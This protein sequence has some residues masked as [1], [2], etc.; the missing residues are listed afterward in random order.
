MGDFILLGGNIA[1][2]VDGVFVH[3]LQ[4]VKR[5]FIKATKIKRIQGQEDKISKLPAYQ[6][7]SSNSTIFVGLPSIKSQRPYFIPVARE[8]DSRV[9]N[10]IR[11]IRLARPPAVATELMLVPY[12]IEWL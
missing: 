2:R 5:L 12:T 8:P 4:R 10:G 7:E 9:P 11:C 6:F 3:E 1:V